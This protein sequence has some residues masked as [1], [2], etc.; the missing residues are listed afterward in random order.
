MQ[1]PLTAPETESTAPYTALADGYD[2]VMSHVNY[3]FWASY[4]QELLTRHRPD[5][6]SILEL[7]CGTGSLAIALQPLGDYRYVATDRSEA[8]LA[9]ARRKADEADVPIE[10]ATA[11]FTNLHAA[12]RFDAAV[13]LYDGLNYLLEPSQV[14]VLLA[15]AFAALS[16][17]GV[18]IVDQST[19]ANSLKNEAFFE[20]SDSTDDFSYVRRSRFDAASNLHRTTLEIVSRERRFVEEHVQRAY[21]ID[22]IRPLARD[23]GFRVDAVYD[24]FSSEPASDASERVHWVLRRPS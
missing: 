18:F 1:D 22:E 20:S 11:E 16:D 15:G 19:P 3:E 7:G 5:T 4:V 6:A 17:E 23:V 10:F 24:G 2:F 14:R 12:K 21:R 8:M 9:V 13:L